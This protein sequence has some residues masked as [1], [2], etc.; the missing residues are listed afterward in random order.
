[1]LLLVAPSDERRGSTLKWHLENGV[2]V[3]GWPERGPDEWEVMCPFEGSGWVAQ[4]HLRRR[5]GRQTLLLDLDLLLGLVQP[6]LTEA[7]QRIATPVT[8]TK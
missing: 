1:M 7:A 6:T 5:L 4:L 3:D 8:Q 2:F